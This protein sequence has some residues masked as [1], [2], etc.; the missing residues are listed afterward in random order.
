MEKSIFDAGIS[1]FQKHYKHKYSYTYE[2]SPIYVRA[3]YPYE[4]L[5]KTE[6]V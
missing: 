3:S 5:R 2:H 4:H 6:P 1:F